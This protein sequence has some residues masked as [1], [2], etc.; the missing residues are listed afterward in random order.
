[1]L[2]NTINLDAYRQAFK[3]DVTIWVICFVLFTA[4]L[5]GLLTYEILKIKK[6]GK[7]AKGKILTII[8]VSLLIPMCV[9]LEVGMFR[10]IALCVKDLSEDAFLVYEGPVSIQEES[11]VSMV[12]R[13]VIREHDYVIRFEHN[14]EDVKL[15]TKDSDVL[16]LGNRECVRI[17]YTKHAREL[18]EFS[19]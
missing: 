8:L 6:M 9:I 11:Y 3:N 13:T 17:I 7:K 18:I 4:I 1:M 2:G 5:V 15:I 10:H 14:G 16:P 12:W 19:N